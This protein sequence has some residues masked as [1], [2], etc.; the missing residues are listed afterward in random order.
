MNQIIQN[1][2]NQFNTRDAFW[3]AANGVMEDEEKQLYFVQILSMR[4]NVAWL[5]DD[6]DSIYEAA[7]QGNPYM[8]YAYARYH[9]TFQPDPESDSIKEQYYNMAI[10]AGIGDARA[11]MAMAYRDGDFGEADIDRYKSEMDKALDEGSD[12]ATR[13]LIYDRMF[14]R[15]GTN[16]D[17]ESAL[18]LVSEFI[19]GIEGEGETV[20]GAYFRVKGD[21][22]YELGRKEEALA[23]YE[24]A[25]ARGDKAAY[26][27]YAMTAACNEDGAIVDE[28]LFMEY[29]DKARDAGA[30]EGYLDYAMLVDE[31]MYESFDEQEKEECTDLLRDHLETAYALADGTAAYFLGSFYAIGSHGFV[32]DDDEAWSWYSCGAILRDRNCY[33]A[34]ADMILEDEYSPGEEYD[35]EFAYECHYKALMLGNSESLSEVIEGY[36][37]GHLTQHAA[38]I[39]QVYLPRYWDE[40]DDLADFHEGEA[41]YDYNNV[42]DLVLQ[43]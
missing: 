31:D 4:D 18:S 1:Y 3:N 27:W 37:H 42:E 41:P 39:E 38:A 13:Q 35:E 19:E 26:Y 10:E 17:P 43:Q 8:Q 16:Y 21:A 32:Q 34:M 24:E 33:A 11:F 25:A 14:G 6:I 28:E 15:N 30:A 29:M 5:K 22:E 12:V 23:S 40:Q 2:I 20:D 7:L 36:Q 9:D